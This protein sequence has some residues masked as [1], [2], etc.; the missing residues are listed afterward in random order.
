MFPRWQL[1]K[2]IQS[3]ELLPCM[4]MPRAQLTCWRPCSLLSVSCVAALHMEGASL[5]CIDACATE[6]LRRTTAVLVAHPAQETNCQDYMGCRTQAWHTSLQQTA[7][8][9]RTLHGLQTACMWHPCRAQARGGSVA[10]KLATEG[11]TPRSQS[12]CLQPRTVAKN[13]ASKPFRIYRISK[14][15][16]ATYC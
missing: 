13:L 12:I 14:V 16:G 1:A 4:N 9:N 5:A 11:P 6:N 15:R 2:P 8:R 7:K 10:G 3:R